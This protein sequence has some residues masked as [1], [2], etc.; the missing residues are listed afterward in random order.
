MKAST[1]L[2]A[3]FVFLFVSCTNHGPHEHLPAPETD[4]GGLEALSYTIYSDKSELFVEFMPLIVG[5]EISFAAHLT[6]LGD[7][8]LPI[9]SGKVTLQLK[10]GNS[11]IRNS[12]HSASSPGIFR[13]ALIPETAGTG[14]LI[15]DIETEDYT[16]RIIIEQVPVYSDKQN[17]LKNHGESTAADGIAFLKEQAW[18]IEFANLRVLKQTFTDVIKTNGKILSAPGDEMMVI[19]NAAGI[20]Q[21]SGNK[22]IVG[23][24]VNRGAKLFTVSGG[25]ITE[26]NID[27]NYKKAKAEFDKAKADYE[28]ALEL[29]KDQIISQ[30]DFLQAKVTYENA[31]TVFQ[32]I[33]KNYSSMGQEIS[34]PISGFVKDIFI[35][36]GQYVEAGMPLA[37]IS[38]NKKLILQANLS[39]RYFSK[40][41]TITRANFITIG[42]DS[43][44]STEQL[45]GKIISYGK[46]ASADSPFLPVS[47]EIDN[48][49]NLIPGS[50]AEVYLKSSS[51]QNA[52][53]IPV[54]A[55]M[56]EQGYFYVYVQSGGELFQKRN[57]KTGASDGFFVQ[58]LSGISEGERVVTKG[59]YQIKLSAASGTMP[60]HGHEH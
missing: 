57:V 4:T 54:S 3:L 42:S 52:L 34:A 7:H 25:N 20:I 33:S 31:E 23:S 51:I 45:N 39:Q 41:P 43:V 37:L 49:G 11:T 24:A 14:V 38:K 21:F 55:L 35:K 6:S 28:R 30:K 10:V 48:I 53:I 29:I 18:K 22:T 36:E 13:L 47:F 60:E 17:A 26:G 59:A 50:V 5:T 12:V 15:F 8:F 40:L 19:A 9:T 16:D 32:T 46:S 56:E 44:L 1:I 2:T 27:S 58:I